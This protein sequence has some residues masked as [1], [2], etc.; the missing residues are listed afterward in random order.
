MTKK[1]ESDARGYAA[2][3]ADKEAR[4]LDSM[5]NQ[6]VFPPLLNVY[7]YRECKERELNLGLDLK[8]G[9][10]VTLE[11]N[12]ADVIR[13][14]SNYNTD[15][16]FNLALENALKQQTNSQT[17]LVTLFGQEFTK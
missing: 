7:T 5:K 16:D 17:D 15:K 3:D 11:L 9:M 1:V 13:G 10:N 4:Y 8:G 12:S 14:L 2:G 6:K